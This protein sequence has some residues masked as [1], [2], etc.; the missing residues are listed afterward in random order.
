MKRYQ[1]NKDAL[2]VLNSNHPWIFR[3]HLSSAADVFKT[4]DWLRLVDSEN[5]TAGYG[6]FDKEG[7]I[8]IRNLKKGETAPE[9]TW[10]QKKVQTAL[11]KREQVRKFST[12]FRAVHGEND[13]LPGIVID[14]YADT[15]VL[16][17]YASSVDALGRYIAELVLKEIGGRNILWKIPKKRKGVRPDQEFRVLRG[18]NPGMIVF[19]E[20]KASFTV[21]VGEGQK[22]G[23]FLDLRGLRKWVSQ[24]KLL[25][26]KV[27][28]LFS[29][30]GNLTRAAEI[31]GAKEIWS[32]DVS[33]GAI[34]FTEK[35][36]VADP[37]KHKLMVADIFKWIDSLSPNDRF[38]LIIVDPP[39]MASK[40]DQVPV[41][42]K[43]YKSLYQS[44]SKH[45]APGGKIVAACCTSRIERRTFAKEV[46][47]F[48]HG[49]KCIKD[50]QPEDDHPVGFD[51][52]DYLKIRIYQ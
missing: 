19:N 9:V 6:I 39:N 37:K 49:M 21:D 1:L 12:G 47:R 46:D 48:L 4:G 8:A 11:K 30:T 35:Y 18:K 23:T 34:E 44:V 13:G 22:S 26:K 15:L 31:A 28:N 42:L 29:Y 25:G 14:V 3:S 16:Q 33:K 24:E 52:G 51:E 43:A 50:L 36:H 2:R 38:D 45:L 32:V 17:T 5:K 20:G 41:A 7:L 27:L 40:K 10:F